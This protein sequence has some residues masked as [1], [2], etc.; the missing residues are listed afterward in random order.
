MIITTFRS[1]YTWEP[2]QNIIYRYLKIVDVQK[3]LN[4][5]ETNLMLEKQASMF[6]SY[7]KL[8]KILKETTDK[9]AEGSGQPSSIYD[10]RNEY[11][12]IMRRYKSKNLD[13]S[14]GLLWKTS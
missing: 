7:D 12:Q 2:P 11:K 13:S 14:S 1:S 6:V 8:T 4:G 10:K 3:F 9:H 5:L